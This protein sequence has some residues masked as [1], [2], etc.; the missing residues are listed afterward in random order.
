MVMIVN[1]ITNL[2]NLLITNLVSKHVFTLH[3]KTNFQ[4]S[5]SYVCAI[6]FIHKRKRNLVLNKLIMYIV[7][8][9]IQIVAHEWYMTR[10]LRHSLA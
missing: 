5:V 6:S 8:P 3:L 7:I 1:K 2:T 10:T 4:T 9:G